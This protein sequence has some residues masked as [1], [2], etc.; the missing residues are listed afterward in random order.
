MVPSVPH[1][2]FESLWQRLAQGR[3]GVHVGRG[4]LVPYGDLS[5]M[6]PLPSL[7]LGA[8]P[9]AAVVQGLPAV[10]GHGH[11]SIPHSTHSHTFF[12]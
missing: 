2:L 3:G 9:A 6:P 11:L 8:K 5:P 4:D 7:C 12:S 10:H 1:I